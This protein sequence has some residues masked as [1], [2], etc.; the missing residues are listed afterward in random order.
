MWYGKQHR[1]SF[2]AQRTMTKSMAPAISM[3]IASDGHFS[4]NTFRTLDILSEASP[5]AGSSVGLFTKWGEGYRGAF[6][7]SITIA[8]ART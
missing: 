6:C 3:N 8:I 4:T 1:D 2:Q 5:T 7:R